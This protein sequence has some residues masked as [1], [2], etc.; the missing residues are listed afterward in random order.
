VSTPLVELRGVD[1]RLGSRDV[2][3][4][5]TFA[6]HP[7]E[8]WALLGANGSGKSSLLRVLRGEIWPRHESGGRRLFGLGRE[9]EESPIGVRQQIGLVSPELQ[10][11]YQRRDWSLRVEAVVR[12]GFTDSVWPPEEASPREG[13][14]IREVLGD[15]GVAQL[16]SRSILS[17]SSGE[18]RRVLLAR[19]LVSR[20]RLLFLDE[21]CHGLDLPSRRAF[22]GLISQVARG[23][24]PIVLATHRYDEL[25]PEITRVAVLH[26]GR[27]LAAGGREEVLHRQRPAN[28]ARRPSPA[29]GPRSPPVRAPRTLIAIEDAD[30]RVEAHPVLRDLSWTVRSGESWVVFGPNGSGKSTLL[31]LVVGDEQAM[32]GGRVSRLELGER[33][34]VWEVKARVGIV[35]PELQARHR[36]D[37]LAEEV[38][39]AGFTA[40]IGID[41]PPTPAEEA[42][43]ARAMA[44][45]GVGHLAGRRIHALS[46]GEVR[47]L[48]LARALVNDPDLLV[49]DE[50]C[51]GLDPESRAALLDQVETLCRERAPVI[52]VTHHLEDVVPAIENVLQLER[53]EVVYRGPRSLWHPHSCS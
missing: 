18:A 16:A 8:S 34:N 4:G 32:P 24:T 41:R 39:A 37:L 26:A 12:S 15:L 13:E 28:R 17:L 5:I 44:R 1:V 21:P 38:V 53:G 9:P 11:E 33:A 49:L 31:R 20:P 43:V 45:L 51:D 22:L 40:S 35:S 3:S 25:V 30:V 27:L 50:P 7:G 48:I 29:P 23:G 36:A 19:A 14:R 52:L 47:K 2:L 46:Y 6:I 42:A 10:Q